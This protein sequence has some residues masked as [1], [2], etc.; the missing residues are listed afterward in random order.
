MVKIMIEPSRRT[1]I[2]LTK[3]D[4][5]S[6]TK[7]GKWVPSRPY[8]SNYGLMYRLKLTWHVFTGKADALYWPED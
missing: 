8:P 1:A 4:V 5:Q 2:E 7:N 6:E 3:W